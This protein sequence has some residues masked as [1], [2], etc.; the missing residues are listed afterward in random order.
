MPQYS[1]FDELPPNTKPV[2]IRDYR[3]TKTTPMTNVPKVMDDNSPMTFGKYKGQAVKTV[4]VEYLHWWWH[5]TDRRDAGLAE[6]IRQNIN[7]LADE[8]ED[9]IWGA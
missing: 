3:T 1:N 7:A 4:P 9:L 5:K 8:N 6:Y 2:P